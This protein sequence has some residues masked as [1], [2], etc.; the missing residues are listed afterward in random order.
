[1]RPRN[2]VDHL[3]DASAAPITVLKSVPYRRDLDAAG[4]LPYRIDL[5][6]GDGFRLHWIDDPA[7]TEPFDRWVRRL[8]DA[9]VPTRQAWRTRRA[10]S[11]SVATVAMFESEGHG[12]ALARRLGI[13]RRVP[14]VIIACWLTD[15]AVRSPRRARIYRFLYGGVDRVV[16]FSENQVPV[17]QRLLALPAERIAVVRFGIDL[18]ELAASTDRSDGAAGD[19]A[20]D[21]APR[22]VAV[23]RDQGRDWATLLAAADGAAWSLDLVTRPF[24]L[25]GLSVPANVTARP[26][27]DRHGYLDLLVAADL[28][29][30]PTH[31]LEYPTG[32][33]VL[34][35]ALALGRACVV[36]DTPAMRGYVTHDETAVLVPPGDPV[37]LRAAVDALVADPDRRMHLGAAARSAALEHG[38]AAAMWHDIAAVVREVTG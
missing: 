34:L 14:L 22:V 36:T 35:E 8:V 3:G 25:E 11:A 20:R 31:V 38:G 33:T 24:Q 5:L 17:L 27:V 32:Q 37:A 4:T 26:P 28:V 13:G 2:P 16:V 6:A 23:G 9:F 18:D 1:M 19:A 21:P 10:R 29:V 7:P 15:L 12:L 30:V